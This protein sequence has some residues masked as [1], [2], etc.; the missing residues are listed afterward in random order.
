MITFPR[1]N[2]CCQIAGPVSF[3]LGSRAWFKRG[4]FKGIGTNQQNIEKSQRENYEA[5][6]GKLLVQCDQAGA[7][8]FIVSILAGPGK[9]RD[10]FKYR[11]KPHVYLGTVFPEQWE[12]EFPMVRDYSCIPLAELRNHPTWKAFDS[13]VRNSDNN[14]PATRYYYHY[15][16]TCHSANYGIEGNTFRFNVLLKSG[17]KVVFTSEQALQYLIRYRELFP[18][19]ESVFQR[20]VR[21]QLRLNKCLRTLQGFPRPI[22]GRFPDEVEIKEWYA[23]IPQATVGII[24]HKAIT[25]FQNFV[26]D[27]RLAWDVLQNGHDAMLVQAPEDEALDCA[28]KCKEFMEQELTFNGEVFRMRSEV[29]I[30]RNW[31]PAKKDNPDGMKEVSI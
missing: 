18:E 1:A 22:T 3:R 30:G 5:D 29:G 11:I 31:A 19:I 2:T 9:Y 21:E 7:D 25:D 15:K 12:V 10:L 23:H 20:Y 24:T 8:A 4:S 17:G 6:E 28:R 26:E 14:P 16:Q 27:E 13:A